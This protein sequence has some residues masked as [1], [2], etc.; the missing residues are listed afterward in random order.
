[1]RSW[2][3]STKQKK[4]KAYEFYSY[5]HLQLDFKLVQ[6]GIFPCECKQEREREM[7]WNW[8]RKKKNGINLKVRQTKK[9]YKSQRALARILCYVTSF[10]SGNEKQLHIQ[11]NNCKN[12]R[13]C[14]FQQKCRIRNRIR[15]SILKNMYF[16]VIENIEYFTLRFEI[17]TS[18]FRLPSFRLFSRARSA[19]KNK[20]TQTYLHKRHLSRVV[21]CVD[22]FVAP[23]R[24]AFQRL[25][26]SLE[27]PVD[28]V[29]VFV[30]LDPSTQ[31]L[32]ITN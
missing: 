11:I 19:T 32:S 17:Y 2:G 3:I 30:L 6:I 9:A 29:L 16:Y 14:G 18:C 10:F 25:V 27:W 7:T 5:L 24:P 20:R 28:G 13:A 22:H 12:A 1:M 23:T 31:P 26:S 15:S 8:E 4:I 21:L